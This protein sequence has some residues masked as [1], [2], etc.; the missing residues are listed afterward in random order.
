MAG[1]ISVISS[2]K[3]FAYIGLHRRRGFK[4]EN[5]LVGGWSYLGGLM[6]KSEYPL[7]IGDLE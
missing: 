7:R 2:L 3:P 4:E 1:F 6:E 5:L